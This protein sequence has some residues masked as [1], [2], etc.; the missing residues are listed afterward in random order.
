MKAYVIL[1]GI[2]FGLITLAH[3][4]RVVVEQPALAKDPGFIIL[5]ALAAALCIW[6]VSL[7]RRW[8]KG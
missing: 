8:P 2:I 4:W 5:T 1:T 7:L 6:A 3:I